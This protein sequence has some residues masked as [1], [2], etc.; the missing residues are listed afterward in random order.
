MFVV[1][2]TGVIF[3]F[4]KTTRGNRFTVAD[5][6]MS[7]V[8]KRSVKLFRRIEREENKIAK[9]V[10]EE[11]GLVARRLERRYKNL[12]ETSR[13]EEERSRQIVL[14][15]E[16]RERIALEVDDVMAVKQHNVATKQ[17][18]ARQLDLNLPEWF[19]TLSE[20]VSLV[21]S[22]GHTNKLKWRSKA[23][24]LLQRCILESED[25]D[26]RSVD[27]RI[28]LRRIALEINNKPANE[29]VR[30]LELLKQQYIKGVASDADSKL[31]QDAVLFAESKESLEAGEDAVVPLSK[32]GWST[33]LDEA[34]LS[35]KAAAQAS[36][37]LS[38]VSRPLTLSESA[39]SEVFSPDN[40]NKGTSQ[41]PA[42]AQQGAVRRVLGLDVHH[43]C[44]NLS[45]A[46]AVMRI[47]S[48]AISGNYSL[49]RSIFFSSFDSADAVRAGKMKIGRVAPGMDVFRC[50]MAAFKNAPAIR[51]EDAFE[52]MNLMEEYR[53]TPDVTVYNIMMRA[54]EQDSRWRRA[55]AMYRDMTETHKILPNV[56]TFD[57]ILDCCRHSLE[58]PAVIF[59]ELRRHKLPREYCY[60]ASVCNCGNRI[61]QQTLFEKMYETSLS[62]LPPHVSTAGPPRTP[63]LFFPEEDEAADEHVKEYRW[64]RLSESIKSTL[65]PTSPV[66]NAIPS[67]PLKSFNVSLARSLPRE[68]SMVRHAASSATTTATT[69]ATTAATRRKKQH[70]TTL[71]LAQQGLSQASW[72]SD[73]DLGD[74]TFA[75]LSPSG[76]YSEKTFQ[77][78][79]QKKISKLPIRTTFSSEQIAK[80]SIRHAGF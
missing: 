68:P 80:D 74:S 54:C 52:V 30:T 37:T 48:A 5:M 8:M 40:H 59:D 13:L 77:P 19:K 22:C 32:S 73:I 66:R 62:Q 24:A 49:C 43:P 46:Q 18:A 69:T 7:D 67:D 57:V 2:C 45:Q 61:P 39:I 34:N 14:N 17:Y 60:R 51:F 26:V 41:F 65:P 31:G 23:L 15:T 78:T 63:G 28:R 75:P 44:P 11:E 21:R 29:L 58:E 36:L 64:K 27:S 12:N 9:I 42:L 70:S 16:V 10:G 72:I 50:M 79:I 25:D 53:V 20:T 71:T 3:A 35:A 38:T 33:Q 6:E 55:L 1:R 56:Q 47:R 76:L 4:G